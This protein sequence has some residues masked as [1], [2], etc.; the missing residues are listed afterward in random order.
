MPAKDAFHDRALV[1]I[2]LD[3]PPDGLRLAQREAHLSRF[4]Q[5]AF[6]NDAGLCLG[7]AGDR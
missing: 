2:R 6:R 5:G 7:G 3:Y 4:G 1:R